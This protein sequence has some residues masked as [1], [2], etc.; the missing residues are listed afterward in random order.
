MDR[1]AEVG[2]GMFVVVVIFLISFGMGDCGFKVVVDSEG[3]IVTNDND[4]IGVNS[5]ENGCTRRR[6]LTR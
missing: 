6:A 1:D 5:S 3:G 2:L 4:S